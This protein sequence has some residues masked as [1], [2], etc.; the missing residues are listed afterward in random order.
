MNECVRERL[1][2]YIYSELPH[3]IGELLRGIGLRQCYRIENGIVASYGSKIKRK[4][5]LLF[6]VLNMS[7]NDIGKEKTE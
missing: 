6:L 7:C 3:Q 5:T 4:K 1:C 2:E